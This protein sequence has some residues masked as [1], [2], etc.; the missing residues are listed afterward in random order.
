MRDYVWI[1]P[2]WIKANGRGERKST[3]RLTDKEDTMLDPFKNNLL[4][5]AIA[6]KEQNLV[7]TSV[8]DLIPGEAGSGIANITTRVK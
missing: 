6:R 4:Y 7:V 5:K 8:C 1:D 3:P 2:K